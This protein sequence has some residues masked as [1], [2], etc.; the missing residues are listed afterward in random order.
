MYKLSIEIEKEINLSESNYAT[1]KQL[2]YYKLD[3]NWVV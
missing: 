3:E 1:F 2:S